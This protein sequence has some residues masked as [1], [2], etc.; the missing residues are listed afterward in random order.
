VIQQIIPVMVEYVRI[1]RRRCKFRQHHDYSSLQ[2]SR[3]AGRHGC[4]ARILA[5]ANPRDITRQVYLSFCLLKPTVQPL[6]Q[7]IP[8]HRDRAILAAY[9]RARTIQGSPDFWKAIEHVHQAP[10]TDISREHVR[11][12]SPPSV[13][14]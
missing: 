14:N 3:H 6:S 13:H 12:V 11:N 4:A 7:S 10:A 2:E 5:R 9:S 8:L 1:P